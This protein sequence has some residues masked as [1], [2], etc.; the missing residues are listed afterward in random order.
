MVFIQSGAPIFIVGTDTTHHTKYFEHEIPKKQ[1]WTSHYDGVDGSHREDS[2][3]WDEH[4]RDLLKTSIPFF[5]SLIS[6]KSNFHDEVIG[7]RS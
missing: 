5:Q 7:D 4:D 1:C 3:L 6:V 2:V